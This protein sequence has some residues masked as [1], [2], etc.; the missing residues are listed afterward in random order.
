MT[1]TVSKPTLQE[2]LQ[3]RLAQISM[4]GPKAAGAK[5]WLA[6]SAR[7]SAFRELYA[8]MSSTDEAKMRQFIPGL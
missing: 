7:L 5:R 8:F 1:T 2:E 4:G 3:T 6:N